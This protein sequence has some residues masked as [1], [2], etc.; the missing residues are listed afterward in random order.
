MRLVATLTVIGIAVLGAAGAGPLGAIS[1]A[2]DG[3]GQGA[4]ALAADSTQP[5]TAGDSFVPELGLPAT[6]VVAFGASPDEAAGEAWAYGRIGA[7]PAS[8]AGAQ[9]SEQY[10]LLERTDASGWQVM[11]L[12]PGPEG[13]PLAASSG[14]TTPAEYGAFAGQATAVGGVVLLSGQNVVVRDPG[15]APRLVPP[16]PASESTS[17]SGAT[18][19]EAEQRPGAEPKLEAEAEA[20]PPTG[21]VLAAGETLLPPASGSLPYAAIDDIAAG[22]GAAHTGIL[23]APYDDGGNPSGKP[24]IRPDVLHYDGERWTREPIELSDEDREHFT[25]LALACA[26][27]Q[28]CWLLAS[29][30]TGSTPS[31]VLFQRVSSAADDSG[32]EWQQ[33]HVSTWPFGERLPSGMAQAAPSRALA[34]GAQMLTATTQGVWVDFQAQINPPASNGQVQ[35]SDVSELIVPESAQT[36]QAQALGQWCYPTGPGCEQSLGASLPTHYRSFAWPGTGGGTGGESG[37]RIITGLS[38]RAMLEL[39][40]G[41]FSYAIGAGGETG[42]GAPGGAAFGSPGEGWIADG[43]NPAIALDG[44]GQAQVIAVTPDPQGDQLDAEALPFRRPLYAVAQAPGTSPGDPRAPAVAVGEDGQI[45]RYVPGLGWRAESLYNSGGEVQT[46]TLRG[47]AWPE[48]ERAYAVG[49]AGEMWLWRAATGLW[50]PDPAKPLNFIGNLQAIAFSPSEES[51]GYAVGR[52]GVLLKYGKSW[53]QVPLPPELSQVNFTSIAFAGSEALATYRVVEPD[54]EGEIHSG[55]ETGGLAV[56]EVGDGRHWHVDPS[57]GALLA[58]LPARN[59]VLSKVAGLSDG[60]AVAAGPGKVIE[61]DSLTGGWRFSTQPLPEAE[62]ISALAAYREAGGPVRAIVSIDLDG[63]L[64]PENFAHGL[65]GEGSPFV[66]DVP[67][68]NALGQPTVFLGPDL[69]PNSGYL[70]KQTASGWSDMEHQALP[71]E[72]GSSASGDMPIRP[73]PVLA[74]LLDPSGATGLAVG[75]ETGDIEGGGVPKVGS[76]DSEY[77]T[78]AALRFPA[79][80]ASRNGSSPAPIATTAGTASFVVGGD[81]ACVHACADLANEGL[82]PDTWLTHALREANAIAAGSS[83][84]VHAFLYTGGRLAEPVSGDEDAREFSRYAAL[85]GDGGGSLPVYAAISPSDVASGTSSEAFAASLGASV[86]AGSAPSGTPPPPAG[87]AA[88][89]FASAG[90]GGTVRVIVL[91]YSQPTLSPNDTVQP[92]C[93]REMDAPENQLQWLCSQLYYATQ[94][95]VPAIVVGNDTLGFRLPDGGG[96]G[97]PELAEARDAGAVSAVLVNGQASA[98]LFDYPGGNVHTEV[99]FGAAAIPAYGTGTLGY[100]ESGSV[101]QEDSLGSSGYLLLSVP[102]ANG[103]PAAASV[104]PNIGQLALDATDGVLLRRSKVALFEALARR[105]PAGVAIGSSGSEGEAPLGPDLYDKIPFDCQGLN[106]ADEVP[107]EYTFASSNPD[108]GNFVAHESASSNPRAV[109]L[110]ANKLPV[111][112]PHSGLFCAFN[113]GTTTVSV[114]T[115]G[116]TYSEPVTILGGSVEYPCGTVPLKHPPRASAPAQA[117]FSAPGLAPAGSPPP[118]PQIQASLPPA[119]LAPTPVPANPPVVHRPPAPFLVQQPLPAAVLAI[120]PPP[121][122]AVA[123]PTPPSGTAGVFE[124]TAVTQEEKEEETA[125]ETSSAFTAY[126]PDEGPHPNPALLLVLPVI[127]AGAGVGIRRGGRRSRRRDRPALARASTRDRDRL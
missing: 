98:Y 68:A 27:A 94:A 110:G 60:G 120:V 44:A 111:A 5:P 23:I 7:A 15:G 51:V 4:S 70:L 1:R 124:P 6:G 22:T 64:D 49:D 20:E 62:N 112:D 104:V 72:G 2:L 59:R 97:G 26:S 39:A 21:D 73:D 31:L 40:G 106:C 42:A 45:G 71:P 9:Y 19:P 67:H 33:A 118:S 63:R 25:V 83:G 11:P 125:E 87:S 34:Q 95:K 82:G 109:E 53:E 38:H 90:V 123:R 65:E 84:A 92:S 107:T 54:P 47:V 126:H 18:Q 122:P 119:P 93:P 35:L 103:A 52:Q 85:L 37:S 14:T 32:Y 121:S 12:P 76:R 96:S 16:P 75:G 57:A 105:P 30:Q 13:K 41:T 116:L 43:A 48:A 113:E 50:E 36:Q 78:A 88:Y 115:G 108:I 8:L 79:G 10:A 80:A 17:L 61:R 81:A 56:E 100:V 89:A 66:I 3:S 91:D 29:F 102:P 69:P 99:H 127:A 117:A 77:Q 101:S 46:P 58:Q 114:T 74:L 28:S 55:I 86:P 24:K